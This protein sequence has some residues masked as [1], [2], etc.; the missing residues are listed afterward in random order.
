MRRVIGPAGVRLGRVGHLSYNTNFIA[1]MGG[2]PPIIGTTTSQVQG[3]PINGWCS[4][5]TRSAMPTATAII[6]A[7]EIT[8]GA[9]QCVRGLTPIRG[10]KSRER[11][12]ST[13]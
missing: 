3:Y 7:N 12:G 11:A 10:G 8:V 6:T 1:D 13:C 9:N 4:A 5:R 2:V